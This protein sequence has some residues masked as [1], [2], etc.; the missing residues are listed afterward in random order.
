MEQAVI[1]PCLECGKA[2]AGALTLDSGT[3]IS[4]GINRLPYDDGEREGY[5]CELCAGYECDKCGENIPLD[6]DIDVLTNEGDT[7]KYHEYCLR[8]E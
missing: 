6:E 2:T 8:G 4:I 3:T 1:D 7:E 5:L